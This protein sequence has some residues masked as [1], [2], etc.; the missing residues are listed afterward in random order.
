MIEI[1]AGGEQ[2]LKEPSP[3]E[4]A[5]SRD[6]QHIS[7]DCQHKSKPQDEAEGPI[8]LG[9]YDKYLPRDPSHLDAV[10]DMEGHAPQW[11]D[12]F[13]SSYVP[14]IPNSH[15]VPESTMRA[16]VM[17]KAMIG[18]SYDNLNK[19]R[20]K[21]DIRGASLDLQFFHP[22]FFSME[23][24]RGR[25]RMSSVPQFGAWDGKSET[26]YSVVFSQARANRRLARH[27]L[28]HERELLRQQY[29]NS[30][31]IHDLHKKEK[32]KKKKKKKMGSCLSCFIRI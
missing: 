21:R 15:Q 14:H 16:A 28:G 24:Y 25:K 31:N 6:H 18:L 12:S 5:I 22:L 17:P 20:T 19:V 30:V 11:Y 4:G 2:V 23:E 27:S 13:V 26:N 8:D 3:V 29:E 10:K 1:V 9:M 32:K 7:G